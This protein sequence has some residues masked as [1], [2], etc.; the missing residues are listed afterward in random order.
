M[1]VEDE[2]EM[3]IHKTAR[4]AQGAIVYGDV[5][6][7][8]KSNIWYHAVVRG[9]S[10]SITIGKYSNVQDNCT[11]HVDTGHPVEIGDYVTIG[12]GAVVHGCKIGNRCLI[13][14]GAIILNDAVI[15]DDCVIG[16]GALIAQGKTIPKGSLVVGNPGRV[17][18]S[19]SEEETQHV[20][21]NALHYVQTEFGI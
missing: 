3:N 1:S 12:H 14:M 18:R 21:D 8:E 5:S 19:V 9:D 2:S 17:M 13:G 4:I 15:E 6:V 10:D 11:V 16:A 20:I 7:G